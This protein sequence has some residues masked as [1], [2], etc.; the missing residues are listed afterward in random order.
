MNVPRIHPD[1][2]EEVK[3]RADIVDVVSE[4]VV[5]KKM[6]KDLVGLCPFHDEGSPSFTVS[7]SKQ[8]YYC[9]GCQSGGN[10][11]KFL[12]EIGKHSFSEVVLDLA[13]RYQVPVHTI[14]PEQRE[15]LQRQL[16]LR[17]ELYE[18]MAIAVRFYEH[19]LHQPQGS[20][21]L[22]Y[23][24][25]DRQLSLETIQQFQLGY[26]P[27][28]WESLYSYLVE[29][30]RFSVQLVEEAGLI[31]A[32]NTGGGYYD[33]FRDRLM[34]PI[35]DSQ[36]RAIAFGG[37]T[38]SDEQP[39]YLNS[40]ETPLFDKGKTLYALDKAKSAISKADKAVVVEGY[41]D[42]IAL[43]AAGI[44]N[45]VASLG[46]ALSLDAV[47]QLLRYTDSKQVILNFDA[48]AAGTTAAERAIGEIA[49][50]AYKGQVQLR[51]INI[52]DGKD[53]D[54]FLKST[55]SPEP[56]RQLMDNAPLWL[57][58]QMQQLLQ[59]ND[60][61]Q[62]DAYQRIAK[63]M[64]NL[65]TKIQNTDTRMYYVNRCA[66]ILS[67]GN[68][69]LVALRAQDL[70]KKLNRIRRKESKS[71]QEKQQDLVP[72]SA[73]RG[74][75]EKAEAV[76]LRLYLHCPEHRGAI[77]QELEARDLDFSLS[78]H[79]F[80]WQ[81]IIQVEY[82]A[83]TGDLLSQVQERFLQTNQDLKPVSELFHLDEKSQRDLVNPPLMIQ[84]AIACIERVLCDKRCRQALQLWKETDLTKEPD[85]A[86]DYQEQI[87]EEK[88]RIEELDKH[89]QV[90]LIDWLQMY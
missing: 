17:E 73:D 11:I 41:F 76:L 60:L 31:K 67:Q 77:A 39:K 83:P 66:E 30:K 20:D 40:P 4:R 50:L 69:T 68:G 32:R 79:R 64:V 72:V 57:D 56:Y 33:R 63:Q 25:V 82:H 55:G 75:L 28:G 74:L 15:E 49:E 85:R 87:S 24:K 29:E 18:I 86:R 38:L 5:L 48:D 62:S 14:E 27:A 9:F 90:S 43:H 58:W 3:Q 52:P 22:N 42:A 81:Q 44:S 61:K 47:K 19:A 35:H 80:L 46:T 26:A 53:A 78:H 84:G 2:I 59:G 13:R 7:P 88:K 65:L 1:T 34:I 89:R 16:S 21:A 23:L 54:D 51:I 70:I 71:E 36:G 12:M 37:R 45:A 6:G 10:A 8:M